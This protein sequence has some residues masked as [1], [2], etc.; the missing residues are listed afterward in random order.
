MGASLL[1]SATSS[2]TEVS[3][4]RDRGQAVDFVMRPGSSVLALEVKSG[5]QTTAHVGLQSFLRAFP[6]SRSLL[7]GPDGIGL[8]EFLGPP[9]ETW[10]R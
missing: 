5:P 8:E 1:N 10:L 9:T 2:A 4:W 6:G 3:Y 7:V